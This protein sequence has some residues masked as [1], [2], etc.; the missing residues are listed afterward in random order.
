MKARGV[1][2]HPT[3]KPMRWRR[4]H[5]FAI[6]SMRSALQELDVDALTI[7]GS[8]QLLIRGG[9]GERG[10]RPIDPG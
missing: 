5:D 1:V 7:V 3:S 2:I 8:D 10:D 9:Y 6:D 4:L